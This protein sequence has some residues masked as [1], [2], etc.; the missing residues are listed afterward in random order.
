MRSMFCG[1]RGKQMQEKGAPSYFNPNEALALVN[2]LE[3][4]L[5][6]ESFQLTPQDIGVMATYRRQVRERFLETRFE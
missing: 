2:M 4:F 1:V 5:S 6:Q 3:A